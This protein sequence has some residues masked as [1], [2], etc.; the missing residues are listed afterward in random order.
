MLFREALACL[1]LLGVLTLPVRPA[2]ACGPEF[3]PQFL[4]DRAGTLSVLPSSAFLIEAG[5]L[6]PRPPDAFQVMESQEP[7]GARTGGGAEETALYEAGARA[8]HAARWDEARERFQDVLALPPEQ[9][10]R[11]ST[12]AAY[13]LGRMAEPAP[14]AH[15]R[16]AAVRALVREGFEDPLGL[17][18]ASLGEEARRYL[19][20]DDA[21]A[22]RLYA[23]QAAHGSET[24]KTSLLFVA[25]ALAQDVPRSRRALHEPVVQ[26]LLTTYAW[27]R[28]HE[29]IWAEDGTTSHPPALAALMEELAAVPTLSGADRLA[30]TAWREGRFDLAERFAGRERTPL[31]AWV[32]AKLALRRGDRA[33]A[34][35]WLAEA[36]E[37]F[38]YEED[39]VGDPYR[40]PLRP[41][42]RVDVERTLLALL[43]DDFTRAAEHA[44]SSCSWPDLAYVAERVLSVEELQRLVAT[45]ASG[46]ELQCQPESVFRWD[47]TRVPPR[48]SEQLHLLLARRLLREGRGAEAL[49][50]FRGTPWEEPARQYV[51]ALDRARSAWWDVDKARALYTAARLARTPGMELLGTEGA[52]DWSWVEGDYE[53]GTWV[54]SLERP[55]DAPPVHPEV[56]PAP[57]ITPAERG[58]LDAHVPPHL[59][60]FHYRS[61]AADL[62]EQAAALVS[63]RSQAYAAL[64]C[65]AARFTSRTEPERGQRLW[66][67]YVRKGALSLE[68]PIPSFGQECPEPDFERLRDRG[69]SLPWENPRPHTLAAVGGFLLPM[70]GVVLLRRRKRGLRGPDGR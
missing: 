62:A 58:R 60:R 15:E 42:V 18:V 35:Q 32:R 47:E 8:F 39:W 13:M 1:S 52:P 55:E 64:L 10:R 33:A 70:L 46:P 63:E 44:L 4:E 45:H 3:P 36:R 5:R 59:T 67:T 66:W 68:H 69:L 19:G 53:L 65:H 40:Y 2:R 27:T 9:R 30:A 57:L 51:D 21:A 22:V 14:E 61:T 26:R 34:D 12:V 37:G 24:G 28:G 29:E 38:P 54:P 11:F 48:V 23:E 50:H 31:D 20:E 7:E 43:R 41:R 17:A 16:F 56:V 25:R 49:E 6:V